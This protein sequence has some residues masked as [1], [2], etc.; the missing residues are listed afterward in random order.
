[1]VPRPILS[2]PAEKVSMTSFDATAPSAPEAQDDA[3][4][5][6]F[7][8]Y[9]GVKMP[10]KLVEAIPAE[11]LTHRNTFIRAY[12]DADEQLTGFDKM[13]YGEIELAHRY[14]YHANGR[15]SRAAVT[16]DEETVILAFDEAGAP[17]AAE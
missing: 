10:F 1:M 5:R 17:I 12:F 15:L 6:Y 11:Q 2:I 13:V 4:C 3:P 16:M 8:T 7:V 14:V 9:T